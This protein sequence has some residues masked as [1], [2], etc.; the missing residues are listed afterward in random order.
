MST[1]TTDAQVMKLAQGSTFVRI[2]RLHPVDNLWINGTDYTESVTNLSFF[3][4]E[5]PLLTFGAAK[6]VAH[7]VDT[8]I[9]EWEI[10]KEYQKFYDDLVKHCKNIYICEPR[11]STGYDAMKNQDVV[12][13]KVDVWSPQFDFFRD[14]FN[15][16]AEIREVE[17]EIPIYPQ[18]L[19]E[20][21]KQM[22]VIIK[23]RFKH[24]SV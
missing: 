20:C 13:W 15:T 10:A 21:F 12:S 6:Y 11:F 1:P 4:D 7:E 2:P 9:N 18:T 19:R 3:H 23:K 24:E 8:R 16:P 22:W 14:L 17:I 5:H